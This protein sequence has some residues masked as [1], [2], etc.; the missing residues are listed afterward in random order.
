[1]QRLRLDQKEHFD[2]RR[3]EAPTFA[4]GAGVWLKD[5]AAGKLALLWLGSCSVL[6]VLRPTVYEVAVPGSKPRRVHV[7]ALKAHVPP[8]VGGH[9][10]TFA[11]A[12]AEAGEAEEEFVV[13]RIN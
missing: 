9:P 6:R 12:P 2:R 1:M 10:L 4:V 3:T 5:S 7:S 11:A 13:E 8:L